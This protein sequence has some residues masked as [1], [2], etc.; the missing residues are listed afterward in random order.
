MTTPQTAR[1][2]LLLAA[3]NAR[4][5]GMKAKNAEREANGYAFAYGEESFFYE[6]QELEKL[7]HEVINQNQTF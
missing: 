7:A 5:E 2:L 1:A 4:I 6:A 3:A